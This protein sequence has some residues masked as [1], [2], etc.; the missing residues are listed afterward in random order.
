[1]TGVS[2]YNVQIPTP[3]WIKNVGYAGIL[4][5]VISIIAMAAC[6]IYFKKTAKNA[7]PVKSTPV[8]PPTNNAKYPDDPAATAPTSREF[9]P[10]PTR[11]VNNKTNGRQEKK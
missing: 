3:A 7:G 10:T 1:M 9:K 4:L 6:F 11:S 8:T 5:S 2:T